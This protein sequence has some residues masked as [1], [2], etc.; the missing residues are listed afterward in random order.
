MYGSAGLKRL[1]QTADLGFSIDRWFSIIQFVRQKLPFL[2]RTVN[3]CSFFEH[4]ATFLSRRVSF[5]SACRRL[6]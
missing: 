3:H 5:R 2:S 1:L 4:G 6:A